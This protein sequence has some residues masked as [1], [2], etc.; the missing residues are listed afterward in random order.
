M[1]DASA[2]DAGIMTRREPGTMNVGQRRDDTHGPAWAAANT[3]AA[4][5]QRAGT[6]VDHETPAFAASAAPGT[7][8]SME[9]RR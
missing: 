4:N 8:F 7:L 5:T 1:N 9:R 3:S 6:S 2:G